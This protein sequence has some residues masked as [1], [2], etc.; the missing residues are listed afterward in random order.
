ML[1]T[2][3]HAASAVHAVALYARVSTERRPEAQAI[4]SHL[5]ALRE[6][7][8][9]DGLLIAPA[10]E[11][12]DDGYSGASLVRPALEQLRDL[13]A[14]GGVEALYVHSPDRLAR[15][16]VQQTLL[17]EEFARVGVRVIFL[18]QAPPQ[19]PEDELLLQVQGVMAEYERA[20]I[21]ERARRGRRHAARVGSVA[22]LARAPYGFRYRGPAQGADPPR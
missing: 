18:N 22:A 4:G 17:L 5:A 2:S 9:E 14:L 6:R 19:T 11:F 10:L 7:A 16:Y 21:M 12:V 20:K 15:K 1:V 13:A 3:P 8:A